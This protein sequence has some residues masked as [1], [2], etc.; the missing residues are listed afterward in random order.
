MAATFR[1]WPDSALDF[2]R[3]L[4]LS[5]NREFWTA[6][7]AIYE[8]D[9]K[10]P[11]EALS[12]LVAEEF[13]PLHVFRPYR[14]VRFSKDKSPY[15]TRCYAVTEGEGGESYYVEISA[16]GL[17]VA[18]GYWMMA[19]DQ[20]DRYR[21]A[22]DDE[23]AGTALERIL[24]DLAARKLTNESPGLKTAPRGY[25]RDHPRVELLRQK[26][27][28]VM[29][30]YPPA[31]WLATPAAADR[32]VDVWRAAAPMNAWLAEHVG[33]STEPPAHRR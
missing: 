30:R 31:R 4:V 11:F 32:V 26:S 5:N 22:V 9:V 23:Q 28:A 16:Q 10:A 8:R 15:K 14:D 25:R 17:T 1:G 29:R 13:G 20:L 6:H 21:T 24:A 18:T 7:K 27:V 2:Y 12:E 3:E 33:P 19:N